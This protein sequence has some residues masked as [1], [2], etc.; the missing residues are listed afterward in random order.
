MDTFL[1]EKPFTSVEINDIEPNRVI[2]L[3]K[4][5]REYFFV[6]YDA[7][8]IH[9]SRF[10]TLGKVAVGERVNLSDKCADLAGLFY[11]YSPKQ[12][13]QYCF[14]EGLEHLIKK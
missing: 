2:E 1:F 6:N 14:K 8:E 5:L 9:I 10:Y 11:G 12:I 13:V 7:K 4:D 3:V